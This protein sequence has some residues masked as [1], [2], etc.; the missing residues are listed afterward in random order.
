[1]RPA[2]ASHVR[3][4]A[5]Q[6]RA[7]VR[8][9][10]GT[11]R[12]PPRR[13]VTAGRGSRR[14]SA[15]PPPAA[16]G[17]PEGR[18]GACRPPSRGA[19]PRRPA[20][21]RAV[22]DTTGAWPE[23]PGPRTPASR[24]GRCAERPGGALRAREAVRRRVGTLAVRPLVRGSPLTGP[25]GGGRARFCRGSRNG[26]K[27]AEPGSADFGGGRSGRGRGPVPRAGGAEPDR[28]AAGR[29]RVPA[30]PPRKSLGANL[31]RFRFR[32]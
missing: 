29:G 7:A 10:P 11:V 4:G 1:V 16:T 8:P 22:P 17:R 9:A 2:P 20:G 28:R 18:G 21:F 26:W 3:R 15:Q 13:G 6:M 31:P 30:V 24:K 14:V 27:G 32:N 23:A 19:R 5:F 12:R 25:A